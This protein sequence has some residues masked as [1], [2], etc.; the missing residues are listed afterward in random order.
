MATIPNARQL[1][2]EQRQCNL[3]SGQARLPEAPAQ[4]RWTSISAAI[5]RLA[6]DF[7][8]LL[9]PA[10]VCLESAGNK[11]VGLSYQDGPKPAQRFIEIPPTRHPAFDSCYLF[12]F[13]KSGSVLLNDIAS[14]LMG[15]SGIP[16]VDISGFCFMNGIAVDT[17][18]FD[19]DE[20]FKPKG[21]CYSGFRAVLPNMRGVVSQLLGK[22]I[23][24]VRDPRDMLVSL[25]YSMAF[26]HVF[27]E[28]GTAQFFTRVNTVRASTREPIDC[29]C[30]DNV[31]QYL[32]C[33]KEYLELLDDDTVKV[34]RYEDVVFAKPVLAR[35]I[36]DWFSLDIDS[37][38]LD[39]LVK[40]FDRFPA[41]DRPGEHIRQVHPGDH[42]RK[43]QPATIEILNATLSKFIHRFDYSF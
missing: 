22:K 27:P 7:R 34:L 32:T 35:T 10:P 42:K 8:D 9:Q 4:S 6:K 26:S 16:I 1:R 17:L 28:A 5:I 31:D 24:M 15:E 29:F 30:V 41:D 25:Y 37:A 2:E 13:P 23:L 14:A 36:R 38:R 40:P 18:L 12:A 33:Y 11:M 3:K 19:L 39:E 43:L 20:I 21:Y